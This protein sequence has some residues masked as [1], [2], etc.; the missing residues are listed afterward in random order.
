[1]NIVLIGTLAAGKTTIGKKISEM[2]EF[3]FVDTDVVVQERLK[4]ILEGNGEPFDFFMFSRNFYP[5]ERK[6]LEE[7]AEKDGLVIATGAM[8]TAHE[9]ILK[10]LRKN[11]VIVRIHPDVESVIARE[12]R[13]NKPAMMAEGESYEEAIARDYH[14]FSDQYLDFDYTIDVSDEETPETYAARILDMLKKN[15]AI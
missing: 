9:N 13:D 6:V 10:F 12:K 3:G 8:A 14:T 4:D 2:S 1:M 7:M 15:G 5:M 11:G